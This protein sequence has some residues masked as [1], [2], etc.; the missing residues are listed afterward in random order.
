MV[1]R[2]KTLFLLGEKFITNELR[3]IVISYFCNICCSYTRHSMAPTTP[4][5]NAIKDM[6]RESLIAISYSLPETDAA[7]PTPSS[8]K[9]PEIKNNVTHNKGG[10]D[11][12]YLSE[13]ISLSYIATYEQL[14][15]LKKVLIM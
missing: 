1:N 8:E 10:T 6:A 5:E 11:V 13:L 15:E 2:L 4:V 7:S 3:L 12:D 9:T 14:P